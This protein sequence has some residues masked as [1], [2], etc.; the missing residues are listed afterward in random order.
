MSYGYELSACDGP[1]CPRCGCRDCRIVR[2]PSKTLSWWGAGRARCR[3]CGN[4]FSFREVSE[5]RQNVVS[6]EEPLIHLPDETPDDSAIEAR[7]AA[8]PVSPQ[9]AR[10]VSPTCPGCGTIMKVSTT[11]ETLRRWKCPK[12]GKTKKTPR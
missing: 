5:A 7:H 2:E 9:G 6:V 8:G 12:C 10:P 4:E 1:A 11:R 3:H